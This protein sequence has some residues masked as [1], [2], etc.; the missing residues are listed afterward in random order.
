MAPA[1]RRL[2]RRRGPLGRQLYPAAAAPS[3]IVE[4]LNEA[5]GAPRAL[6]VVGPLI[7]PAGTVLLDTVST[8]TPLSL[9]TT[10]AVA[11]APG[12]IATPIRSAGSRADTA[13]ATTTAAD[14]D[15]VEERS[16]FTGLA[17]HGRD[18]FASTARVPA[19]LVAVH[20]H[21]AAIPRGGQYGNLVYLGTHGADR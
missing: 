16:Q 14:D 9:L 15:Y 19:D 13:G 11:G 1:F 5:T 7:A 18:Q 20:S 21:G 8:G 2:I 17:A 12:W 6:A 3:Q 4:R 10:A